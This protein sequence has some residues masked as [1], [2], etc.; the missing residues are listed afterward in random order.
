MIKYVYTFCIYSM[1]VVKLPAVLSFEWDKG[2][3]QKNWLKHKVTS[4]KPEEAFD[5]A[6]RM[7]FQ[8]VKHS[9]R[10]E[11][12][13]LLFAQTRRKLRIV[14]TMCKQKI[15]I[16]SARPMNRKEAMIYKKAVSTA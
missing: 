13:F 15:R 2:N 6:N 8:D 3:E 4:E 14:F 11:K 12:R 16:I 9:T 10:Q 1:V 5:D 7:I